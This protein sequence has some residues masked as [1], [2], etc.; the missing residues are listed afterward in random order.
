MMGYVM[1]SSTTGD[2]MGSSAQWCDGPHDG[3]HN[4]QQHTAA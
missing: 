2:M 1:G 3:P 4:G